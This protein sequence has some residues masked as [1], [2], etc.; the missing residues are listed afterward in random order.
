MK[1]FREL[2]KNIDM[3]LLL[4]PVFFAV[5]SIVMIGSTA[6]D[7]EFVFNRSIKVQ[8][9][10]FAL[11]IGVLFFTMLIDYN[12][13]ERIHWYLYGFSILFLLTV[14]IPGLGSEQY[15]ARAWL[16]LKV[17]YLQPAEIVKITFTLSYAAFLA[18]YQES[19]QTR[20]GFF[21]AV[22]YVIPFL[23]IIVVLQNDLGNALVLLV[24]AVFMLFAAGLRT[25]IFLTAA[26]AVCAA[27]PAAY[28]V[29][30]PHQRE[31]IDAFLHPEDL[32]LEGNYQVW[33]SKVAIGSG[34]VSGKGLF[35]GTQKELKFLP[36]QDS[37]F[38]FS[39]ICEEFGM[40]GGLT[41]IALYSLYLYRIFR[42]GTNA[43][44][45]YGNLI[46]M[47]IFGMFLFQIFE[48]IGMT[49][50]IMPVT[51]ITLPFI[52]AGGTS[53][54]TNMFALG[55]ILNICIRSKVINF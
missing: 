43:K 22:G 16:D 38:I 33:N 15:G 47:G 34:G 23:F 50:G 26:A 41:V 13:F 48:N 4:L 12:K 6:Y 19:L 53:V 27:V 1:Y 24:G 35:Q 46:V 2:F 11:G 49:M 25:G 14:F 40:M 5:I 55:I 31:R 18:K 28:F 45:L 9:V 54:I 17:V 44:D 52:S 3:L 7:G 39:V 51:G 36:V 42:I 20:K 10:A 8:R 29:M 37:D 30:A 32:S 21:V